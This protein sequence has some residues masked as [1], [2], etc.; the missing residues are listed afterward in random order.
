[1]RWFILVPALLLEV[2][3]ALLL[4]RDDVSARHDC[5]YFGERP[6]GIP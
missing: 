1:M 6:Y 3:A 2:A 4:G 5:G